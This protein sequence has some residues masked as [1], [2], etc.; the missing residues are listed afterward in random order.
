MRRV[1]IRI[2]FCHK[3]GTCSFKKNTLPVLLVKT[4]C[5][6]R[7]IRMTLEVR[8]KTMLDLGFSANVPRPEQWMGFG[9][10]VW[11]VTTVH[12][13]YSFSYIFTVMVRLPG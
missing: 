8:S 4:V 7:V 5:V 6:G 12:G 10:W 2:D 1:T 9:V 11:M 3:C 13:L